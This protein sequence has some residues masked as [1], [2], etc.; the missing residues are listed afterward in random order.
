M[1]FC[2]SVSAWLISVGSSASIA[3]MS[4]MS[5]PKAFSSPLIALPTN[6]LIIACCLESV[7]VFPAS[8]TL[9]VEFNS[10]ASNVLKLSEPFRRPAGFPDAP[11]L[12][13]RSRGG[14]LLPTE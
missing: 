2:S 13:W 3:T 9:I 4:G 6:C 5:L 10:L 8:C 12:N 7:L 14:R 1:I 11:G